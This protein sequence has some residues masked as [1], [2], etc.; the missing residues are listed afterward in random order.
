M[1]YVLYALLG[2]GLMIP[3]IAEARPVSYPGGWTAMLMNDGDKNSAHIHYSPTAK[4]SVGYR[5]EY[6]RDDK[7][8]INA[9]QMN[10]LLKRWNKKNSQANLYL[11]SG[12][13]IADSDHDDFDNDETQAAIFTGLAA[14]WEDRRFFTAYENRY[15]EA[16]DIGN[17]FMQ[18]ARVGFAPYVG[19]YGDL[20]TWLMLEVKH[21]PEGKNN[22]SITPLVRLFKN[23]HLL[24]AGINNHGEVLFNYTIRY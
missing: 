12:L 7:F 1:R 15:L 22:V 20:H 19:D 9:I 5:F 13:G 14:D 16:G 11:K 4:T 6:R 23:V 21:T 8:T 24:E 10:N 2:M 3:N 18:S 17:V